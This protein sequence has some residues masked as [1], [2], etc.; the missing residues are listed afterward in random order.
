MKTL[1]MRVVNYNEVIQT[2]TELGIQLTPSKSAA[3]NVCQKFE[4]DGVAIQIH[5]ARKNDR[6]EVL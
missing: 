4:K 3:G 5:P 2:L 1:L 6:V